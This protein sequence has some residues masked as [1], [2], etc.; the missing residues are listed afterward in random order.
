MLL[1]MDYL[2][3][4]KMLLMLQLRHILSMRSIE[5]YFMEN[6]ESELT[7]IYRIGQKLQSN[8][9]I[10]HFEYNDNALLVSFIF[11]FILFDEFDVG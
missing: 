6:R 5:K 1:E 11:H 7:I 10:V 3:F 2:S 8:V 9:H 4:I